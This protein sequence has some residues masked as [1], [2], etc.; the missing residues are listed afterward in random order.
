MHVGR[1][2]AGILVDAGT[3]KARQEAAHEVTATTPTTIARPIELTIL[4]TERGAAG[5]EGQRGRTLNRVRRKRRDS[6]DYVLLC[7]PGTLEFLCKVYYCRLRIHVVLLR[8]RLLKK[9]CCAAMVVDTTTTCMYVIYRMIG[10][11]G[12]CRVELQPQK[13][14]QR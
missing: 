8:V 5:K 4:P 1:R 9:G 12:N 3:M 2:Q 14:Q 13:T 11:R 7:V 6:G 10:V